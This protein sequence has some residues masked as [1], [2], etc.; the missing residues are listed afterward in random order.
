[1]LNTFKMVLNICRMEKLKIRAE[2]HKEFMK[3]LGKESHAYSTVKNEQQSLKGG[4]RALRMMDGLAG[5]RMPPLMKTSRKCT[6]WLCVKRVETCE[7]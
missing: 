7:A 1:M 3:T 4:V 6:L 5:P 2:I